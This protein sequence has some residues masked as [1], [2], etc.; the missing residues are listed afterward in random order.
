MLD[1]NPIMGN[2]D[3]VVSTIIEE[4]V[5]KLF[6][7]GIREKDKPIKL[8]KD[9]NYSLATGGI[10]LALTA[11]YLNKTYPN[12]NWDYVA[13]EYIKSYSQIISKHYMGVSLFSGLTGIA[14][15]ASIL[16]G[17]EKR[18][19]KFI[20]GINSHIFSR[21]VGLSK[22]ISL[23]NKNIIPEYLDLVSGAVGI[24]S[25]LL[26]TNKRKQLSLL[27]NPIIERILLNKDLSCFYFTKS[28]KNI[29]SD[30]YIDLGMAHGITG[31]LS[32]LSLCSINSV[33][34]DG[35]LDSIEI[36]ADWLIN[37]KITDGYGINWPYKIGLHNKE[38]QYNTPSRTAWCYGNPGVAMAM[39]VAGIATNKNR[40]KKISKKIM[41]DAYNKPREIN[42]INSPTFCH[43][44][45]GLLQISLRLYQLTNQEIYKQQ[46]K[47]MVKELSIN[48]NKKY[49]FGFRDF[50]S[51]YEENPGILNG[52]SGILLS[53]LT[54]TSSSAPSWD[55][56]FL[57]S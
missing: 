2:T 33:Q 43:G 37:N 16:S 14:F 50:N 31:M 23:N 6:G 3:K 51:K 20:K 27:L 30:K 49:K 24:I 25:Y 18:Y 7:R 53:L 48:F 35:I 22:K 4:T 13:H 46:S 45:S 8:I 1:W 36:I 29:E 32:L 40:Y 44:I 28:I 55:R 5:K 11:G 56:M 41:I 10:G 15:T 26:Y 17:E 38:G 39:Q 52:S 42:R 9:I 12:N 34:E 21:V 57:L 19:T 47:R 54:A